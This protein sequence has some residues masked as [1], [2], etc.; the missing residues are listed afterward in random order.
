MTPLLRS[1]LF[2]SALAL[3]GCVLSPSLGT[4]TGPTVGAAH[5]HGRV[6]GG[7]QPVSASTI[8]LYA[9]ATNADGGRATPLLN[10]AVTTDSAGVFELTGLYA[11]PTPSALVYLTATGGNPGISQG[12]AAL[13]LMTALG[14]CGSL[15]SSTFIHV[16]ERTTIAALSALA[17][18]T[19]SYSAIGSSPL[20]APALSSAF[21][22][23]ASYVDF[24][25][26]QVPGPGLP[27]NTSAPLSTLNSLADV[28]ATCVNSPGGT[29]GDG[30]PC[31]VLFS[32]TTPAGAVSPADTVSALLNVLR[33]PQANAAV[34]YNLSS[35]ASPFQPQLS[36]APPAWTVALLGPGA[37][38]PTPLGC[39]APD[40]AGAASFT[41]FALQQPQ[42]CRYMTAADL[43]PANTSASSTNYSTP[44]ARAPGQMPIVPPGFK[45]TLYLQSL[46]NPRYLLAVPNGDL[47]LSEPASGAIRVLRGVDPNG[48]NVNQ[49]FFTTGLNSPYGMAFY[50]SAV[51]PQF[52]YVANTSTLLRYPY[53]P[54]DTIASAAPTTLA[55]DLP[56][57]GNHTTRALAFTHEATPR[58]LVSVGSASNV[59][60][61]DTDPNEFRRADVLAYSVGG[62]FQKVFASGL[63]NPVGLAIDAAGKVWT[64]VNERDGLG[65]NTPADYVTHVQEDGFYGWPWYY[66]GPNPEPR[67]PNAHPELAS[68]TIVGDTLLQAH[69]APLQINFYTGSNFPTPYRGDLFVASHGSWNKAVRSGYELLR[70]RIL[71]GIATGEY[72]DFLTGFV[73]PDGTVWGRPTGVVTGADGALY[74][75]D[76][77][78]NSIWRITY[79]GK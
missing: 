30:S 37:P 51:S 4:K 42:I 76:D 23:A 52:L 38:I 2:L 39:S 8:Q 48:Y 1:A 66:N 67:L 78:S 64:S 19:R 34:L 35:P 50:P 59:T 72:E 32:A 54:G 69:F 29:A 12:N 10:S 24:S 20:S 60:N 17:P 68:Q 28:L 74:V 61:T 33:D 36:A 7:Q 45:V 55:T 5:P 47:L 46:S 13:A 65:D 26:G 73:N 31:G 27:P 18:F 25:T 3:T 53:T 79:T 40:L 21:A 16:D 58:L 56:S 43:P 22:L 71:N 62:T 63:R 57:S 41:N 14:A 15:T 44:V 9:V 6:L 49:T 11:C 77:L 75:A 70:V